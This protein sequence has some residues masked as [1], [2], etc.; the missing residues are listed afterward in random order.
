MHSNIA[1]VLEK[2]NQLRSWTDAFVTRTT[3]RLSHHIACAPGCGVC[4]RLQSVTP[5]EAYVIERSLENTASIPP[6]R[7]AR[8]PGDCPFLTDDNRCAIY[9]ARP[10]ICRSHGLII[11]ENDDGKPR[12]T[13]VRNFTSVALHAIDSSFCFPAHRIAENLMR[14]NYAFCTITGDAAR[15]GNRVS[16]GLCAG[17]STPGRG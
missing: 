17:R 2:Y 13:C 1:R 6:R 9:A 16:I 14:L 4:C 10:L 11:L 12:R 5:L 8:S 7:S 15:A 3:A